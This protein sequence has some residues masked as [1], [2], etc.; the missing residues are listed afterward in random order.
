MR[1]SVRAVILNRSLQTFLVQYREKDKKD[2]GK[3]T[4]PGFYLD[5]ANED[6]AERLMKELKET[7]GEEFGQLFRVGAKLYQNFGKD[8]VDHF[9]FV[10]FRGED[11]EPRE[12]KDILKSAWFEKER[13][14]M[15]PLYFGF[16][17]QLVG[18]AIG[19]Y[20]EVLKVAARN[21]RS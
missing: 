17:T 1:Q 14:K 4:T 15:H 2:F 19:L 21:I 6:H 20:Q 7:F 12:S 13:L 3:W 16:E 18:Q 9:Y 8:R 5:N 11:M 10:F